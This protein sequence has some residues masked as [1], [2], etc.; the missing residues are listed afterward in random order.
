MIYSCII[1]G[2]VND[3]IIIFFDTHQQSLK[4]QDNLLIVDFQRVYWCSTTDLFT[5]IELY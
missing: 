4:L 5:K 2:F 3:G 1:L